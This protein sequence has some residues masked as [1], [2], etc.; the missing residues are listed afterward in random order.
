MSEDRVLS[1]ST[2]DYCRS[3][4]LRHVFGL[5]T[6]LAVAAVGASSVAAPVMDPG[7]LT[8]TARLLALRLDQAARGAYLRSQLAQGWVILPTVVVDQVHL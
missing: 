1:A 7:P 3:R 4:A 8:P 5:L 6:G 2:R